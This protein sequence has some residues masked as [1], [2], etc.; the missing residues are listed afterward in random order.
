M[1]RDHAMKT[2]NAA[3]TIL[4]A[5]ADQQLRRR[6]ARSL[7]TQGY[8]VDACGDGSEAEE[9]IYSRQFDAIVACVAAPDQS[10]FDRIMQVKQAQ[11]GCRVV[12]MTNPSETGA[13]D[14][15]DMAK[16]QGA[17]ACLRKPFSMDE[18]TLTLEKILEA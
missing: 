11:P 1:A 12:A 18:L 15:S 3:R 6:M 8:A 4:V 2:E 13:P 7:K 5:D 14:Y 9:K 16:L 10:G 17:S